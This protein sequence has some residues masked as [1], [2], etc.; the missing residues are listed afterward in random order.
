MANHVECRLIIDGPKDELKDLLTELEEAE[1][2]QEEGYEMKDYP[3]TAYGT[4][5]KAPQR[6]YHDMYGNHDSERIDLQFWSK[7]T[8]PARSFKRL[9]EAHPDWDIV[10]KYDAEDDCFMGVMVNRSGNSND[11]RINYA[12]IQI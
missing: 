7:W 5:D 12:S 10:L 8:P 2:V 3:D 11:S 1:D 6:Y 9:C 4:D